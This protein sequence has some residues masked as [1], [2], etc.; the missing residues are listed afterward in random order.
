M[1]RCR[2]VR[3]QSV[4]SVLRTGQVRDGSHW[5]PESKAASVVAASYMRTSTE[6]HHPR[7]SRLRLTALE[8]AQD[9]NCTLH[10]PYL[11]Y[12]SAGPQFS[13]PT[14]GLISVSSVGIGRGSVQCK[15]VRC[16]LHNPYPEIYMPLPLPSS[17]KKRY[18]WIGRSSVLWCRL[19][20]F[21]LADDA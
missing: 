10:I 8:T 4:S 13:S 18:R 1:Q 17:N 5:I 20:P 6:V 12:T 19:A 9:L 11:A 15:H 7:A 14:Y 2:P 16:R 21:T 3:Y